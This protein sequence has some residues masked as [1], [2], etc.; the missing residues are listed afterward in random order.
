[1]REIGLIWRTALIIS[2]VLFAPVGFCQSIYKV[3]IE[4]DDFVSR[5]LFDEVANR[6]DIEIEY[7]YYPS[8]NHILEAV[9]VSDAD[10]AANVTYTPERARHFDFSSPTNIEFTYLYSLN[11]ETLSSAKVVGIPQGTIYGDLIKANFPEIIQVEYIGHDEARQLLETQQVDG[12]VDAINQLK[13]MLLA[14]YDAQLLNNQISI[15]PVSIIVPKNTH[16]ELLQAV[17]SYLHTAGVQKRLR[18][19]VKQYQFDLRQQALRQSVIESNLNLNR[20]YRVK[21]ENLDPFAYYHDDGQVSGL[22]ADVVSKACEILLMNC[23]VV[24]SANETWESMYQDLVTKR[25]DI[26]AP[27][28]VSESRRSIAEFSEPYYFPEVVMIKRE[29]YNNGVYSNVSELIVE[30]IGVLKDDFLAGLLGQLL[31]NKEL[32]TYPSADELYSAL[33]RGEIDYL[34]ATRTSFN[35]RLRDANDLLPLEE[36]QMIGSFYRPAIA[37]GFTKNEAGAELAPLF[38]R[39]IKMIDI[40]AL[41]EKYDSQPNWRA[42]LQAQ[43]TFSRQS[44]IL[45]IMV[46]GFMLVVSMYLHSQSNTDS[47]TRL[48]NRRSMHQRFS[49]GVNADQT[50]IYLDVNRF[51]HINDNY[52]HEIGDQVLKR[53]AKHIELI[54][55]GYSYRIGGDEFILIGKVDKQEQEF[56]ISKLQ[57]VDFISQDQQLSFEISLAVGVSA[58]RSTFMSLQEVLNEADE[59]MYQHKLQSKQRANKTQSAEK[60]VHYLN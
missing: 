20:V 5:V 27:I 14:G 57:S 52:G 34:P 48:K 38:S 2:S 19:S 6:F 56:V 24:S 36:E 11:N 51:K 21:L 8:F 23:Q 10:F 46:L 43:Q 18:E 26:L 4:A 42:T 1:M 32:K 29:G 39:A 22:S 53:V 30:D 54:W 16:T 3:G 17:E 37:I 9:K 50:V 31:P 40:A 12:V 35:M 15:K 7:V 28:G 59:A 47:L 58:Q 60:N 13:P 45:L 49:S 33:L 25:I 55:S 41:V 44:H